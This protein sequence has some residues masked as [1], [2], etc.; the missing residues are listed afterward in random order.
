MGV[1]IA[2]GVLAPSVALA[3]RQSVRY[4]ALDQINYCALLFGILVYGIAGAGNIRQMGRIGLK[5]IIY[6]EIVTRR[7]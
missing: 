4:P 6:F 1:G 7:L 5:A 2:L 3:S